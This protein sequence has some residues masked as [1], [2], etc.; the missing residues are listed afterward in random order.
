[1]TADMTVPSRRLAWHREVSA[2]L[3][4]LA[5]GRLAELVAEGRDVA[6]GIGGASA[7][8]DVD[9]FPVFVKR[10]PLTDLERRPE[11]V[12]STANL[13]GLPPFYQYGVG[14][15]GFG[16]W[17]ELTANRWATGWVL[18]GRTAAFP[19]MYHWRVLPGA[20]APPAEAADVERAVA[21]WEGSP[22]VR[23]RLHALAA[24]SASLVLFLEYLPHDLHDWLS[25]QPEEAY[26]MVERRLRADV[27]FMNGAGLL[28]FDAHFGNVR[29]DGER[30]YLGDLGL[31]TSPR[32]A[33][34]AAEGEFVA[35][36]RHHDLCHTLTQLVNRLERNGAGGPIVRRY[37][38]VADVMNAFYR[39]LF[40]QSRATPYPAEELARAMAL[41]GLQ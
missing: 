26:A 21:Y 32:F 6:T 24:A 7:V 12:M 5:D 35:R 41:A 15:T 23:E 8:L 14:S 18:D 36:H 34:S 20:P 27:A 38:P 22:A 16:A 40:G 9:G 31:A 37:A 2:R 11:N 39:R 19:L 25:G 13:F 29:T 1:M 30:L 10:I 4:A 28:H 33:L 3:E 17:R